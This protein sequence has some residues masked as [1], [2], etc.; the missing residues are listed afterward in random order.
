M[1]PR[2]GTQRAVRHL[3]KRR[4]IGSNREHTR[5][6]ETRLGRHEE[7]AQHWNHVARQSRRNHKQGIKQEIA[8]Q[9][10]RDEIP[11]DLERNPFQR[12]QIDHIDNRCQTIKHTER[13]NYTIEIE[14]FIK[15]K[16]I[17]GQCAYAQ[18]HLTDEL[19]QDNA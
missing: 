16:E 15:I 14:H 8:L 4:N 6:V 3:Y 7:F 18:S 2:N 19:G 1:R 10:R 12:E 11:L 13:N 17:N 9:L 5:Q